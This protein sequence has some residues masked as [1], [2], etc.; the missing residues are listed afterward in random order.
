MD[1]ICA[2]TELEP[3]PYK[4]P[5]PAQRAQIRRDNFKHVNASAALEGLHPS[6]FDLDIQEQIAVGALSTDQ[7]VAI[8]G[9][10]ARC[11]VL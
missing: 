6:A 5:T 8:I 7:A 1:E 3:Q 11:G 2:L 4:P 10:M 9:A